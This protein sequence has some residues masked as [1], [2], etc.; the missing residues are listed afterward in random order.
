MERLRDTYCSY[1]GAPFPE[2][3]AYPRT[4]SAC[5]TQIW[6][7]P[8]PVCVVLVPILD[9]DRTGLLVIRR[10]INPGL[11]KLALVGGFLEEHE[12][13][14]HGG[15]REV[16]EETGVIVDPATLVPHWFA[17]S[18]P[19]PNRVQLF[20]IAPPQPVGSLPNFT[21]NPETSERGVIYGPGGLE[22]VFAFSTHVEATRRYF[23]ARGVTDH[24]GFTPR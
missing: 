20:S 21:Q 12:P 16:R 15:A 2:P 14:Q 9:G 4:C 19:R 6:A 11:G 1:C 8:I 22:E 17:S 7:N 24:H 23:G 18:A 10:A 3:L 5:R 13:W